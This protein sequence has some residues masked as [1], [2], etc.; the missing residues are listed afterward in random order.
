MYIIFM[1]VENREDKNSTVYLL[2]GI[3]K[4]KKNLS[5]YIDKIYRFIVE[6]K[7]DPLVIN[8][9]TFLEALKMDNKAG[10][11]VSFVPPLIE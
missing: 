6:N 1:C 3:T 5:Q 8:N 2:L 11:M 9:D 4:K 7:F 10:K